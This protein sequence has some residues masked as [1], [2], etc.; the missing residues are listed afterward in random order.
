MKHA[1]VMYESMFGNTKEI[2]EA[3]AEGLRETMTVKLVEV[4]S[5]P[6]ELSEEVGLLVVGGP[7]HAFSMSRPSTRADAAG[8]GAD[9]Q[10]AAGTGLREWAER[11]GKGSVRPPV[12]AFDTKVKGLMTG[13]AARAAI[14]LL[15]RAHF[16][17]LL[18]PENFY[19]DGTAGP[20]LEGESK[21]AQV[22]GAKCAAEVGEASTPAP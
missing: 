4:G 10:A 15:R 7:T 12:A 8:K 6:V 11:I 20:L 14:K 13:S 22:W 3:V 1:L 16:P 9:E 19:V 5:A 2:A 17:V 21:R 18:A